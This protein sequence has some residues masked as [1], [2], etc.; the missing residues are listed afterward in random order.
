MPRCSFICTDL[1]PFA[2]LG[3]YDLISDGDIDFEIKAGLLT[4]FGEWV[5]ERLKQPVKGSLPNENH[6]GS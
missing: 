5:G 4:Q 1:N 2:V 3:R 6:L